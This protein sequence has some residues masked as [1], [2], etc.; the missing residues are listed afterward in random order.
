MEDPATWNETQK[1]IAQAINEDQKE[2]D[3]GVC[4]YSLITKIY[5]TLKEKDLLK[6]GS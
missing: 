4:G 5:N 3:A 1:A 2:A 6:E